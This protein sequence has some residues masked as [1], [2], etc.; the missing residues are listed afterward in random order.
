MYVISR[1][2]EV[3]DPT[4]VAGWARKRGRRT[5]DHCCERGRL[6]AD[7]AGDQGLRTASAPV[8]KR[9]RMCAAAQQV[10]AAVRHV[11]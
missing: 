3:V 1:A 7:F 6:S 4:M 10:H 11:S 8:P 9:T 2:V 5:G